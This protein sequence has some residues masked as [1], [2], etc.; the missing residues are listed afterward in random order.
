MANPPVFEVR[1]SVHYDDVSR[2]WYA[3]TTLYVNGHKEQAEMWTQ[4]SFTNVR[5]AK[6]F[7]RF[8]ADQQEQSIKRMVIE[9]LIKAGTLPG[10]K[11]NV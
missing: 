7:A 11:V 5:K 4:V 8:L 3:T 9:E 2:Q 1:P 6:Q 10:G